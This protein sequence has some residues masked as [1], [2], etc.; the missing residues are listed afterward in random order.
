MKKIIY[1]FGA[2]NGDD[3]PYYLLKSDVVVAVEANS[4][5]C[6]LI[7]E[8]F[9]PQIKQGRV[10][11]E[12]CVITSENDGVDVDFYIHKRKHVLSRF[13]K[14]GLKQIDNFEKVL[15]PSKTVKR[16]ISDH[17]APLYIKIDVEHY[18]SEILRAL[19]RENIL[20]PY[21]SAESHSIEVFSLLVSMGYSGFKL[22][23]GAT[24]SRTYSNRAIQ[25]TH[26]TVVYSFPPHA[27][28]PFGNDVDGKWMAADNFFHVLA[29]EGLGW[30]DIHASRVEEVDPH[31][32]V[33]P[34]KYFM[35]AL[36]G[37]L[38]SMARKFFSHFRIAEQLHQL[39]A[40]PPRSKASA[41]ARR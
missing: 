29:L 26:S 16:V 38:K 7:H 17:G 36:A 5:L 24:V 2:N 4:A 12:N 8:R 37:K 3:I 6:Q 20:P 32:R 19:W 15:L 11:V 30:K 31:V 25:G 13:P 28:G 33:R 23:N 21:I 22:V 41:D 1:D 35:R 39:T 40:F 10:V 14:P 27:A 34:R 18:D 9:L